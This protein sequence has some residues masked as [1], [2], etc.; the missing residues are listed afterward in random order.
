[1][2]SKNAPEYNQQTFQLFLHH[3][4][5]VTLMNDADVIRLASLPAREVLLGQLVRQ[6]NAPIQGLHHALQWNLNKFVW[7]L[8]AVKEKKQ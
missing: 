5:I 8:N 3:A 6:L 2:S 7:A 4:D 1:M